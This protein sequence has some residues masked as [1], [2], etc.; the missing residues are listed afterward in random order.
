MLRVFF[1][2]HKCASKWVTLLIERMCNEMGWKSAIAYRAHVDEHG[3]LRPFIEKQRPDFL[4]IPESD[5]SLVGE[6]PVPFKGFHLIRDPRD[7]V[8]SGYF[9]HLKVHDLTTNPEQG[10]TAEHRRQLEELPKEQGIDLEIAT[11]ARIPL[12]HLYEWNYRNPDILEV[13]FEQLTADTYKE[14]MAIL[15]FLDMEGPTNRFPFAL[16]CYINRLLKRAKIRGPRTDRYSGSQLRKTLRDLSFENLK[17]GKPW[18][19]N[20]KGAHYRKGKAGDWRHH[21]TDRQEREIDRIFPGILQ[22]LGYHGHAA[23][24]PSVSP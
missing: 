10:V 15:T 11:I 20:Q 9:S 8:V 7:L 22:K 17:R 23:G 4:I 18:W 6:I 5:I 2:Q 24:H 1:G 19:L 12:E 13:K 16:R 14:M 3:G 21:L